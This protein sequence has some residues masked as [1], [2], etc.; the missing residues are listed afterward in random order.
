MFLEWL[1]LEWFVRSILIKNG[2]LKDPISVWR[3][4]PF[5]SLFETFKCL[6]RTN[7]WTDRTSFFWYLVFFGFSYFLLYAKCE[8]M[9]GWDI[10]VRIIFSFSRPFPQ[11]D[12]SM[13]SSRPLAHFCH[14]WA[15]KW[16]TFG[17]RWL[18]LGSFLSSFCSLLVTFGSLWLPFAPFSRS[19]WEFA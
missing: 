2:S 7:Q 11:L 3:G 8:S 17:S 15:F 6:N 5:C 18:P 14:P 19:L 12:F 4:E 16:L 10:M 1:F 9:D 13:H